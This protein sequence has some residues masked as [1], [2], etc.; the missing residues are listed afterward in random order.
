[1]DPV[2]CIAADQIP[3]TQSVS[4]DDIAL[5]VGL[6]VNAI[7]PVAQS[8]SAGCIRPDRVAPD[9]VIVCIHQQQTIRIVAADQIALSR[10]IPANVIVGTV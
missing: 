4:T 8:S 3:L 7:I 9:R 1:M 6:E 5:A 10:D 2:V